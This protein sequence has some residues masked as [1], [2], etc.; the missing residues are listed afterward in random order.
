MERNVWLPLSPGLLR[1]CLVSPSSHR[2]AELTSN[3]PGTS[4]PGI[5]ST[6][7]R[8]YCVQTCD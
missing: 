6:T 1:V 8:K 2:L 5:S 3:F 4:K 7:A